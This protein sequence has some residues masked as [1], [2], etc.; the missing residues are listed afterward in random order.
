MPTS[1]ARFRHF[2]SN[3]LTMGLP[4]QTPPEYSLLLQLERYAFNLSQEKCRQ[5]L[6]A[7]GIF[8]LTS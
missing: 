7:F 6:R 4:P 3:Q 1:A 5:A 2:P 8:P